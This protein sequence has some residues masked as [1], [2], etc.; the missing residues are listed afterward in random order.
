M[1]TRTLLLGIGILIVG[2]VLGMLTSAQ[3]RYNKLKPMRVYFAGDRFREGF[4]KIIQPDDQQK[5]RIDQILDK[6][7]RINYETQNN[8]RK[9]FD[10]NAKA[11]R[12]ELESQLTKD[13]L[14]RLK[15]M[16]E[17][18]EEMMKQERERHKNDTTDFR[19]FRR[20]PGGFRGPDGGPIGPDSRP[21]PQ[22]P[23]PPPIPGE[24]SDSTVS[25]NSK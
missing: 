4:Y 18:R 16:D 24:R 6:Y 21:R 15:E 11:M 12:K 25:T 9:E 2:F 14:A 10:T 19:R 3:I 13:Q 8:F 7:A 22:G 17:R 5:S 20:P 23:T 1:K